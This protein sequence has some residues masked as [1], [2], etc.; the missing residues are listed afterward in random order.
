MDN[1]LF[2]T[3]NMIRG[4]IF[5]TAIGDALGMPS[6]GMSRENIREEFGRISEYH[7][8]KSRF[9]K[10]LFKGNWTDDTKLTIANF[11]SLAKYLKDNPGISAVNYDD[12]SLVNNAIF[13]CHCDRE[14]SPAQLGEAWREAN[15]RNYLRLPRSATLRSRLRR[16]SQ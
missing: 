8:S 9:S 3:Q 10:G 7:D 1:S 12:L 2:E 6:E 5:G 13:R 4:C 11:V 16:S 14:R 15:S